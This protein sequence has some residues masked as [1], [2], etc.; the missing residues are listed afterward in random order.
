[1]HRGHLILPAPRT[2]PGSIYRERPKSA[3]SPADL[4]RLDTPAVPGVHAAAHNVAATIVIIGIV[5]YVIRVI[6]VVVVVTGAK[7]SADEEGS[8]MVEAVAETA[9]MEAAMLE[10]SARKAAAL[11]GC[12][13]A[14]LNSRR[15]PR[16]TDRARA[17][18]TAAEPSGAK[19][20]AAK[21]TAMEGAAAEPSAPTTAE[22]AAET[23]AMA[24]TAVATASSATT[25]TRQ[26]HVRRQH[27]N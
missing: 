3:E 2:I 11:N 15:N 4:N 16:G 27:S 14:A 13:A 21:P 25:T 26:S 7:E 24:S 18:E 10:T 19:A 9:V 22:A 8:P 5:G 20:A 12:E 17:C 6:I 1:M 23:T